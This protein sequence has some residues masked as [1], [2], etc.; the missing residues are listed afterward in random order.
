MTVRRFAIVA[1]TILPLLAA[2]A[3]WLV[4]SSQ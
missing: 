4:R 3:F 2:L 1:T